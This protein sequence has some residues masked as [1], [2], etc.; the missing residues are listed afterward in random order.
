MWLGVRSNPKLGAG[1]VKTQH[2][3]VQQICEDGN[4]V[5]NRLFAS[6]LSLQDRVV[7]IYLDSEVRPS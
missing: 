5:D 1:G 2:I 7:H 6:D 4:S 3:R